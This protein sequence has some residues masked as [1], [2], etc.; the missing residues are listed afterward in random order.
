[1][2]YL[3]FLLFVFG[4]CYADAGFDL[5]VNKLHVE[6]KNV[7]FAPFKDVGVFNLQ[8][9]FKGV[10]QKLSP[11]GKEILVALLQEMLGE[12]TVLKKREQILDFARE[13]NLNVSALSDDDNFVITGTCVKENISKLF[14]LISEIIFKP[15]FLEADLKRKKQE[16]SA[17][18]MQSL[19][20]PQV[21]LS[22]LKKKALLADHPYGYL[23]ES[24]V[25][26]LENITEKD[27]RQFILD[28]FTLENVFVSVSGD[29]DD[30]ALKNELSKFLKLLPKK[31]K[32]K[33]PGKVAINKNYAAHHVKFDV[34]QTVVNIVHEGVDFNHPDFFA[35]QIASLC[36][37]DPNT[38]VL[39]RKVRTE[40]GLAYNLACSFNIMDDFNT[41]SIATATKTETVQ[42]AI[43]LIKNGINEVIENGFDEETFNTVKSSFLGNYKRSFSSTASISS[44]LLRYMFNG[45]SENRYQE[46]IN[47]IESLNLNDVN[48]AFKR[49]F[50]INNIHVFTVGR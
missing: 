36:L 7:F 14:S 35:L 6:G 28:N 9:G 43:E 24:Y 8:I 46:V 10:G 2:R 18:S 17:A 42:K 34:P 23:V 45:F 41:F 32:A 44:R 30:L 13:N 47:T 38:G 49:F 4:F 1:M 33:Q 27:L 16:I 37:G 3:R 19:Q 12:A 5:H 39:W 40:N 50:N 31:L 22:E 20:M 26:S 11:K 21:Q 29:V 48:E 25:K 15:V